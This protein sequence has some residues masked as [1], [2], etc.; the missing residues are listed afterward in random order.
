M[1][2][3][4]STRSGSTRA[5]TAIATAVPT[6]ANRVR[7]RATRSTTSGIANVGFDHTTT[8]PRTPIRNATGGLG[9][10][11]SVGPPAD[12]ATARSAKRNRDHE[13]QRRLA[14]AEVELPRVAQQE[15]GAEAEDRPDG[16]PGADQ[17]EQDRGVAE[18]RARGSSPRPP[19]ARPGTRTAG[20]ARAARGGSA[21][22]GGTPDPPGSAGSTSRPRTGSRRRAT[23][24]GGS[25][26]RRGSRSAVRCRAGWLERLCHVVTVSHAATAAKATTASTAR[27]RGGTRSTVAATRSRIP[28]GYRSGSFGPIVWESGDRERRRSRAAARRCAR[29]P[30][31]KGAA[32]CRWSRSY[33]RNRRVCSAR[34]TVPT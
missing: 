10:A 25:R 33:C 20:A 24:R 14:G 7:P 27:A 34:S 21:C 23:R 5:L 28:A 9:P 13:H 32:P 29:T 15:Q 30:A 18:H 8:T 12:R 1:P 4:A 3:A 2:P 22:R 6:A 16:E 19:R 26:R 17:A 11:P 31:L